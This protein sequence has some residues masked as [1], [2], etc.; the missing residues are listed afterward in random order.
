MG[1][2]V[3]P[4]YVASVFRVQGCKLTGCLFLLLVAQ[5]PVAIPSLC[6]LVAIAHEVLQ[7]QGAI[8]GRHQCW[9]R[10]PFLSARHLHPPLRHPQCPTVPVLVGLYLP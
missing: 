4:L 7:G 8:C 1:Q 10:P 9:L 2:E 5:G 6:C 3:G